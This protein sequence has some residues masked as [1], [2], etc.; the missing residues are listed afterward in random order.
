MNIISMNLANLN[1]TRTEAGGP[2]RRKITI[3]Q[4]VPFR[5]ELIR[6]S[7][8]PVAQAERGV[9]VVGIVNAKDPFR[10]VYDPGHPE[11]DQDGYVTYPNVNVITE[12]V[13]LMT[14]VRA[15]EANVTAIN[16]AK[17]MALKTLEIGR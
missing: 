9:K 6:A 16:A 8:S 12:M 5:D 17:D 7:S 2:Y 11:A 13:N 14:A 4:S 10:R 1:T 15:Y 3:H